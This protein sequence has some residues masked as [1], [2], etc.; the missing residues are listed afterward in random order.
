MRHRV[1]CTGSFYSL[2]HK[3]NNFLSKHKKPTAPSLHL[4]TTAVVAS[5]RTLP[6]TGGRKDASVVL[7]TSSVGGHTAL[8]LSSGI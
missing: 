1:S 7:S 5:S 3:F 8:Y 2:A 6:F 4:S